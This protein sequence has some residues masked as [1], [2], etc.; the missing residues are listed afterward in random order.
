M[1][2][3]IKQIKGKKKISTFWIFLI[4]TVLA[5]AIYTGISCNKTMPMAEGWYTYYAQLINEKGLQ[6]YRDFEFLFSPV[7]IY[8][9]ALFTKIFGYKIIALRILGVVMFSVI[10]AG[11]YLVAVEIVGEEKSWIA[12]ISAITAVYYLQSEVVQI[13]YDYIRLMDIFSVFSV[14]FLIR[15][16]KA[17][18][19]NSQKAQKNLF[20]CGT[21]VALFINV[22]QN[23]GL[24]FWAYTIVLV[25]FLGV[26]LNQNIK[27]IFKGIAAFMLP[28]AI[29]SAVLYGSLWLIGSLSNFFAMTGAGAVSAKG[30]IF[31]ILFNWIPNNINSFRTGIQKA[32]I[33][34]LLFI[35]LV[36]WNTWLSQKSEQENQQSSK[37][38]KILTFFVGIG[39][40]A[41][42]AL[43]M[44][45]S[46]LKK[47]VAVTF[48]NWNTVS[49]YWIF[50]IVFPLFVVG[51]F[52]FLYDIIKRKRDADAYM[53]WFALAGAYVAISWGCGNSGGLAEGQATFGVVILIGFALDLLSHI[54]MLPFQVVI[55][56][57]CVVLTLQSGTK[58]MVHTYNWWGADEADFWA[59]SIP[60][61]GV[62]L[63]DGIEVSADTKNVYEEICSEIKDNTGEVDSIYCFPQIPIFY[64]L[65]NRYDSGTKAKVEWFDVSTDS[66]VESDIDVLKQNPPKAVLMY[67][68]SEYA[69]SSHERLFRNGEISSMRKMREFLFQYVY[70]NEYTFAG[71]YQTGN[72][73]LLLWIKKDEAE[74]GREKI[75]DG[76][77]GT[78][79]NPYQISHA[80][81][82]V[83]LSEMVND[84][85]TFEGQYIEQTADIDLVG[86]SFIPIGV[87]GKGSYFYGTYNGG[88]HKICNLTVDVDSAGG[89][90]GQLA[91]NVY[92]LGLQGGK[93]KGLTAGGFAASSVQ[94]TQ[95][96]IVNC[97]SS[98]LVEGYRAGGIADDFRGVVA[99]CVSVGRLDGIEIADAISY[100]QAVYVENV[101]CAEESQNSIYKHDSITDGR[102]IHGLEVDMSSTYVLTAL[103]NYTENHTDLLVEL[104]KWRKKSD[105]T[106]GFDS[107]NDD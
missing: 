28:I 78:Q 93:V 8:F 91:G 30:G 43:C 44:G 6:P 50:D 92:N 103:N 40:M 9:I 58:K 47:W 26:Y 57:L 73:T 48:S 7:Y 51:G 46:I 41:I 25:I 106:L 27:K 23:M 29:I 15:S 82:L 70:E 94:G 52:W 11:V 53:L 65:C 81:Q 99:N 68:V 90:F 31:A 13:F 84:G 83:A 45:A 100:N 35:V 55:V 59:S 67:D 17:M 14:Y 34:F 60:V 37:W 72:N 76:G 2:G 101:Y 63:L 4:F 22:K 42:V 1:K 75:F 16:V 19:D 88:G 79:E 61:E 71:K 98:I 97:Y 32:L 5:A 36:V 74:I 80:E 77:N 12:G 102:I 56:G 39:Y 96:Q 10:A 86:Y 64:S 38:Y 20:L 85:R 3:S 107:N 69:M 62:D 87:A 54:Y 24:I 33:C 89:L 21:M 66:A 104:I 49:P 18:R 95:P 105:G